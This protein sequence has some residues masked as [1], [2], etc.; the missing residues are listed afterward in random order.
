M[1][2]RFCLSEQKDGSAFSEMRNS[3]ITRVCMCIEGRRDCKRVR[4]VGVLGIWVRMCQM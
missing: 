2:P 4:W 1:T 3:Q